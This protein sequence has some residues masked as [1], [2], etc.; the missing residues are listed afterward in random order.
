MKTPWRRAVVRS[1]AFL[2]CLCLAA[3]SGS[4]DGAANEPLEFRVVTFNTGTSPGL[5]HDD[6]PDDG[7]SSAEAAISDEWYG[8]G[9]AWLAAIEDARRFLEQ[10]SPDIVAF[11]EIFYSGDCPDIPP[12][13]HRGWACET[14]SPGAPTVAQVVAGEGYQVACHVGKSDKC[15]AV[16]RSFG[17]FRG[18]AE[19][20][21]LE[22]LE[23]TTI[24]GCG[25]GAR[26]G[27]AV[28]DL[29]G[30]GTLTLVNIHGTSGFSADDVR[31]R[32]RQF[33]Q[34]F[35]NL[36]DGEPAANGERN[37]IVGDLNTDPG[38]VASVDA[39]AQTFA[40]HVGPDKRFH[41]ISDVGPDAAPTY[42][43][44]F[45]IDYVVSDVL[46]GECSVPGVSEGVPP[47]SE[48]VYFDHHPVVCDV[49]E[50][51]AP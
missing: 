44:L 13:F 46:E 29:V 15:A 22:G 7:Y 51:V 43:G 23:G 9:L 30:G 35:L 26:V 40:D 38:R 42:L 18:C 6:P 3:C 31:C 49:R 19:D 20:F 33:E 4:D 25:Q 14:W 37:V 47:V 32:M 16:R 8:D 21:C 17:T 1:S 48:I 5:A 10:V 27:R 50:R 11:Q 45:N 12:E 39:S 36:G 2:A 24:S 41:F 34:V 28:I